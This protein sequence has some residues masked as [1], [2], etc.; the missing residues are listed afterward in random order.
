M[1]TYIVWTKDGAWHGDRRAGMRGGRA[2]VSKSPPLAWKWQMWNKDTLQ[3]PLTLQGPHTTPPSDNGPLYTNDIISVR[4]HP[5]HA[6]RR[7]AGLRGSI[8]RGQ[9]LYNFTPDDKKLS[10]AQIKR[11][12]H[13]DAPTCRTRLVTG[14]A[15]CSSAI[16]TTDWLRG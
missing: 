15:M 7:P 4:W 13:A 5:R 14:N 10:R 6:D 8:R 16:Y 3:P 2:T 11:A 1:K 9:M 12:L